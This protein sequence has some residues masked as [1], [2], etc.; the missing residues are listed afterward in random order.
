M[1]MFSIIIPVKSINDYVRE[2]VPHIQRLAGPQWELM[3]IPN[4]EESNE[5][6][7]D[8][9]VRVFPSGR[10]GPA[11]KRDMGAAR[12]CGEILVFLDDD[13]YPAEDLLV[14]AERYFADQTIVAL[15]GPAI[16]P[17]DDGFW[18]RVS[19]AVFLSKFSGGAPERYVP[20][21]KARPVQDWPSVNLMVQKSDFLAIGGFDSP[22]WPGEDTKLCLDLIKMTGKA[23]MYVPEMRVWHHRR[24]G[25]GAHLRQVGGYGLHR[26]YFAKRYPETSRRLPYFIPT[27]FLV[28]FVSNALIPFLNTPLLIAVYAIWVCYVAVMYAVWRDIRKYETMAVTGVA[29]IYVMLTHLCYGGRFAQGLLTTNLRSRLR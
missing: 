12:A 19:G 16:T 21:G 18:Q 29:M 13:S 1:V 24:A 7:G 6:P 2:T 5:W 3:V 10:V 4:E 11:A 22:Y 8:G 15:G 14:V 17:P 26:G 27:C 25:L 9:R 28:F 23:I 20:I